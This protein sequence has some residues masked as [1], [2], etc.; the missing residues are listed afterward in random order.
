MSPSKLISFFDPF[1]LNEDTPLYQERHPGTSLDFTVVPPRPPAP[2]PIS[3]KTLSILLSNHP[4]DPMPFLFCRCLLSDLPNLSLPF[5]ASLEAQ[6]V[7]NPPAMRETWV[8]SLGWEDP[9]EKGRATH[10]VFWPGAFH[11]HSPWSWKESDTT[12]RLSLS[13]LLCSPPEAG[14]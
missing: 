14:G 9:L 6:L 2:D 7:K 4:P 5:W 1:L 3:H 10:S 12:E 13:F 11:G 8:Q